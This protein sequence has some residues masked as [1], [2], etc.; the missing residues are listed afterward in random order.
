MHT[1]DLGLEPILSARARLDPRIIEL[2][3]KFN[4]VIDELLA[5]RW[6][7]DLRPALSQIMYSTI[8]G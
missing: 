7:L 1:C 2:P 5:D 4:D 8:R 6:V 3:A